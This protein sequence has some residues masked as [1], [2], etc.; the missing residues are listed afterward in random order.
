MRVWWCSCC[1]VLTITAVAWSDGLP[2]EPL[3]RRVEPAGKAKSTRDTAFA[4][5]VKMEWDKAP[6]PKQM[7]GSN[8]AV[9]KSSSSNTTVQVSNYSEVFSETVESPLEQYSAEPEFAHPAFVTADT[10]DFEYE[11]RVLPAGLMYKSYLA[12]EKEPRVQSVWLTDQNGHLWWETTLGGRFAFVRYGTANAVNPEGW[13]L[14]FEGAALPRVDPRAESSPLIACDYRVGLLSTW[15]QGGDGFKAGYYHLSSHVG[16]EFLILNPGFDRLN[17]VRDSLIVG[18]T[19]NLNLDTQ[20][21]GEVA[22]AVL[23]EA[24]AEP[25]EF[26]YGIQYSPRVPGVLGAPFAAINGHTRQEFNYA[27]SINIQTGWQWWGERTNH[28]FRIG[29]QYYEGPSLQYS[30][31]NKYERLTGWGLWFDY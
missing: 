8:S 19:H 23:H 13:E 27:T 20:I 14:A 1:L 10:A 9:S 18:W 24:G 21:Y 17:Y 30:F 4:L 31:V 7:S 15:R 29:L 5:Q 2:V 25:L 6:E 16:D 22:Y 3:V 12:G 26:Q 28:T 11:W